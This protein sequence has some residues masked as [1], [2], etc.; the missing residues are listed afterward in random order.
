ME[1]YYRPQKSYSGLL[2]WVRW[3]QSSVTHWCAARGDY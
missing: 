2:L 3:I 1:A